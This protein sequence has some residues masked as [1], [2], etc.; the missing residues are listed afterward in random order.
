[1]DLQTVNLWAEQGTVKF[2][3]P[4]PGYDRHFGVTEFF[5]IE[6]IIVPMTEHGYDM[7]M[8]EQLVNTDA[9]IKGIWCVPQIFQSSRHYVF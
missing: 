7:D 5:G 3:C 6:M 2:L 4:C 9:S 8:V 1:M